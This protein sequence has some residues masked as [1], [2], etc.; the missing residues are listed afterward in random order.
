MN[1]KTGSGAPGGVTMTRV[2]QNSRLRQ[3]TFSNHLAAA[4]RV[5]L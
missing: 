2:Q 3:P 4:C 5:S 1:A